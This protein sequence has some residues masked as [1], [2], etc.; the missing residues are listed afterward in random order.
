MSEVNPDENPSF[1]Q[2]QEMWQG[3]TFAP[4]EAAYPRVA[5]FASALSI[6]FTNG[7]VLHRSFLLPD[8]PSL[9]FRVS[10]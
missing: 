6:V 9:R 10:A 8:H 1:E 2:R 3:L 4:D 5:K 7:T